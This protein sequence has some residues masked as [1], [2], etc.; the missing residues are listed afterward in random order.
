M[1]RVFTEGQACSE[2]RHG[3]GHRAEPTTQRLSWSGPGRWG[4]F[5]EETVCEMRP[6][7][8]EARTEG[9]TCAKVR[10]RREGAQVSA[11]ALPH[12]GSGLSLLGSHSPRPF[13]GHLLYWTLN[14]RLHRL[15]TV[16]PQ[17]VLPGIQRLLSQVFCLLTCPDIQ[18]SANTLG[19]K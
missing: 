15:S 4:G 1:F 16:R 11:V 12:S 18:Y 9:I 17:E 19:D 14:L 2:E 13:T 10:Q 6:G 3:A 5:P 8:R 7:G